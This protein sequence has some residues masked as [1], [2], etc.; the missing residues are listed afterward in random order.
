MKV[1][2][3]ILL[4]A[5]FGLAGCAQRVWV[6]PG[7]DQQAFQVDSFACER[8]S[9]QSGG[10]GGGLAGAIAVQE[11]FNRCMAARGWTLQESSAAE[12]QASANLH[13][14]QFARD[15]RNSCI[16]RLRQESRF[17]PI[18]PY[19]SDIHTGR[20]SFLQTTISDVPSARDA[21]LFRDYVHEAARC[22]DSFLAS[23][24]SVA[25]PAQAEVFRAQRSE[26]DSLAAQLARRQLSW[27]EYA[28]RMNQV[29]DSTSGRLQAATR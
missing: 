26:F 11:F 16:S 7:A 29:V 19:F 27:G 8:D 12:A 17:A 21:N 28:T 3:S 10:F 18:L 20:F 9:R 5:L 23:V 6:K 1:F 14:L 4:L 2:K 15:T 22:A 13:L 25:T 24:S